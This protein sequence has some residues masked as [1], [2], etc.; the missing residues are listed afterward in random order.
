MVLPKSPFN[1]TTLT[2]L[3]LLVGISVGAAASDSGGL[4][5]Q[6]A[7]RFVVEYLQEKEPLEAY[8]KKAPS[9]RIRAAEAIDLD[10][11]GVQEVFLLL[12]PYYSQTPTVFGY[13]V[14]SSGEVTRLLEAFAP[15]PLI[16][17]APAVRK[18]HLE[19]TSA[20]MKW[21]S[22][23]RSERELLVRNTVWIRSHVLEFHDYLHTDHASD[24]GYYVDLTSY[25]LV[26]GSD[27]LNCSTYQFSRGDALYSGHNQKTGSPT[28][29]ARV[30]SKLYGY[31]CEGIVDR[32]FINRQT[33]TAPVPE[34]FKAFIHQSDGGLWYQSLTGAVNPLV[35]GE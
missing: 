22:S 11:D 7:I 30:G 10:G 32:W 3:A 31:T 28:L 12:D 26:S 2:V 23:T 13:Q 20:D 6:A 19:R 35:I 34:D 27:S 5:T 14:T 15:G 25:P 33:V 17:R 1:P 29:I 18:T 8:R 21:P 16:P 24:D 9:A 4:T